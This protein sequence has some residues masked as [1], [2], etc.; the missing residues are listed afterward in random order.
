MRAP[1]LVMVYGSLFFALMCQL[2]PWTGQGII[3]RPDFMLVILIYWLLRAPY[4]CNITTAWIVGLIVDLSTG[5]LLGQH[6]LAFTLTAFIA[7][8]FQRRLVLFSLIQISLFV[9]ALLFFTRTVVLVLKLFAG[10]ESQS[11]HYFWPIV[12]GLILWHIARLLFGSLA[13]PKTETA[14]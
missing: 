9:L 8:S 10:N 2:F 6:A 7:L 11:W 3:L 12:S 14:D 5:S 13:R 1:N 4:L